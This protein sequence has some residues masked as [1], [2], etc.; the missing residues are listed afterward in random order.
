MSFK[1][2]YRGQEVEDLLDK[3]DGFGESSEYLSK[4]EAVQMYQPKGDY[5]TEHQDISGKVDKVEGKGLSTEDFTT[6]LKSKLESLSNFDS[7]AIES[8]ISNIQNQI[9]TL[10]SGDASKAIESF[11]EI[12]AFLEGIE[13]SKDLSSIIAS[14]EWQISKKADTAS[15]SE[16][17]TSGDYKDLKNKPTIPSLEGYATEQYVNG[18]VGDI[19][20]ILDSIINT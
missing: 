6:A 12:I 7:S 16:V 3:I 17:A 8:S 14:I 5:L 9:N 1:S 4:R 13:D 11:N 20:S 10:V 19:D 15:L 18:I 2:K